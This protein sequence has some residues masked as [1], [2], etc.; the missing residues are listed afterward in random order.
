MKDG[1]NHVSVLFIKQGGKEIL[2]KAFRRQGKSK[3]LTAYSIG[4][5]QRRERWI[6]RRRVQGLG[7][8]DLLP[9][10]EKRLLTLP[11]YGKRP[12]PEV[13]EWYETCQVCGTRVTES[14][15]KHKALVQLS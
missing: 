10:L 1:T 3:F 7:Y 15:G 6:H 5:G 11:N 2:G 9:T 14:D 12:C 13:G 8:G 4:D